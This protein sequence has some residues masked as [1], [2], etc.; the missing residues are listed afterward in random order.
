M[1]IQISVFRLKKYLGQILEN[2]HMNNCKQI[3]TL[4]CKGLILEKSQCSKIESK[5]KGMKKI[6]YTKAIGSL[7]YVIFYVLGLVSHHQAI[8]CKEY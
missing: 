6:P 4:I 7:M 5:I 2:F 8:S 1:K 3:S